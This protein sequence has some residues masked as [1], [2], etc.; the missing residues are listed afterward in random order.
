[1]VFFI[2]FDKILTMKKLQ[3]LL[4]C[5]LISCF[6]AQVGNE[7]VSY[8][9]GNF[10]TKANKVSTKEYIIDGN[11]FIDGEQFYKVKIEGYNKN[12]QNFRYNA[13]YDEMEFKKDNELFY[14]NKIEKI[15]IEFPNLKKTYQCI[16]YNYNGKSNF[17]YL[18]LLAESSKINLY[19]KEK[20]EL[21]KGEKSTNAFTKDAND[22]Y[23]SVKD[24]F[25]LSKDNQ[26]F[27]FPKSVSDAAELFS[28]NKN[29][30]E[31]FIKTNKIN[32]SKEEG[33]I[34]LVEYINQH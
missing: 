6:D 18:I 4:C 24:L 21:L 22:Y 13:F 10:F 19:K 33:M 16:S 29:D 17:G 1:M 34:K 3:L 2:K 5:L 23:A 30:L 25:L 28:V 14:A 26:F 27:K 8:S 32:I 9:S 12:V 20:K 11:P 15:K 31:K 7:N